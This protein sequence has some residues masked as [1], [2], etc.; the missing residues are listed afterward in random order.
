MFLA[1]ILVCDIE[2]GC[3]FISLPQVFPNLYACQMVVEDG[4]THFELQPKVDYSEGR[5]IRWGN[6]VGDR[7]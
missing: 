7:S 3:K 4:E 1:V 5:C 2:G 6:L